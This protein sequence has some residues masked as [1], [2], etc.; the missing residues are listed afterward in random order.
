MS[1]PVHTAVCDLRAVGAPWSVIGVQ[2]VDGFNVAPSPRIGGPTFPLLP[3]H[4]IMR[5][6]RTS[7]S[8]HT[9]GVSRATGKPASVGSAVHWFVARL[10][11]APSLC[12]TR[13]PATV[14]T[15]PH[16]IISVPV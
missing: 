16:T 6:G 2:P 4:T 14:R 5:P 12:Q 3:A 1:V 7:G 8:V 15:P 11:L 13:L 10:Y 9:A